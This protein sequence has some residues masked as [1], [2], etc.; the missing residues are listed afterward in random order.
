MHILQKVKKRWCFCVYADI[1]V[2][3]FCLVAT[4]QHPTVIDTKCI[5]SIQNNNTFDS[6]V[7]ETYWRRDKIIK[8]QSIITYVRL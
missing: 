8:E 7:Q 6:I 2:C 4:Q 3:E 1:F 5:H